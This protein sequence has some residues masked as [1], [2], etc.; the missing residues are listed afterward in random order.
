[1]HE[2]AAVFRPAFGMKPLI[3][4][5]GASKTFNVWSVSGLVQHSAGVPPTQ[6]STSPIGT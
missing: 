5:S 3:S 2:E 6:S 1:V 4:A